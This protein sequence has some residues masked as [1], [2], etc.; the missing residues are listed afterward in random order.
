MSSSHAQV[1]W[2]IVGLISM[3]PSLVK[4]THTYT[5]THICIYVYSGIIL[6]DNCHYSFHVNL[7]N[8]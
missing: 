4:Y 1:Q 8:L 6:Y 3:N 2:S 5:L 7:L